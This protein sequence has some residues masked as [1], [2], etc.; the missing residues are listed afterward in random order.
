M[1]AIWC[2]KQRSLRMSQGRHNRQNVVLHP[3][4]ALTPAWSFVVAVNTALPARKCLCLI[5]PWTA[6]LL[7]ALK[8]KKVKP[9]W[10]PHIQPALAQCLHCAH[11]WWS[12]QY[13]PP[14]PTFWSAASRVPTQAVT[15]HLSQELC[16]ANPITVSLTAC[17]RWKQTLRLVWRGKKPL[18]VTAKCTAEQI[19]VSYKRTKYQVA[20]SDVSLRSGG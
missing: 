3:G 10:D 5:L 19:R 12:F 6:S 11:A 17:A 18:T 16:P 1:L 7:T 8:G 2:P 14:V 9:C 13:V 15:V 20:L 4:S